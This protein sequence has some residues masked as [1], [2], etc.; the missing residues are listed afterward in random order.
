MFGGG[1]VGKLYTN[2]SFQAKQPSAR[3]YQ[4]RLI[5]RTVLE[6]SRSLG[7]AMLLGL[8]YVLQFIVIT[9]TESWPHIPIHPWLPPLI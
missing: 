7:D 3:L 6:Y 5:F 1:G 9:S 4:H 2:F 8:A